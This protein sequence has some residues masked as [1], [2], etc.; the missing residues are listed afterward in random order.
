MARFKELF[1][2]YPRELTSGKVVWY[3]QNYNDK[4]K[5]TVGR[6]TGQTTE[7]KANRW[8]QDLY[9]ANKLVPKT[10]FTLTEWADERQLWV[11]GECLYTKGRLA[12]SSSDKPAISQRY[13][14]DCLRIL[15]T[16][17]LPAHGHMKL[18]AITSE[19]CES[20]FFF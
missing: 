2:L 11:W 3:Y 13:V 10:R 6:S 12:R 8:C 5:R 16:R 17:I 20:L 7:A 18:E 19:D 1:P 4:G 15:K 9:K 14:D